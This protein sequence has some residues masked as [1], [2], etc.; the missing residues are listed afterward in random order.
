MIRSYIN[1]LE[2]KYKES[3][4]SD[5]K[6]FISFITD[7]AQR[8]S[9][10]IHDLLDYSRII[11]RGKEFTKVDSNEIISK[12][13]QNL[14]MYITENDAEIVFE[15]LPV[16]S[17]D[18]SQLIELFQNLINNAIKFRGDEKPIVHIGAIRDGRRWRFSVK[19]NGIGIK[20]D[21]FDK[22][23]IMFQRLHEREKYPGT[24]IGL[25]IVKKVVERHGGS[26]C[27]ESEPGKGT[28]FYFTLPQVS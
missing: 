8:M 7:G 20:K 23:F 25:A 16:V 10:L 17:G 5:A 1:L 3:L 22:I 9:D 28:T 2:S 6:Q 27:V 11:T 15:D 14:E 24:G 21:F 13:I 19:D 26:I 4:D 12:V 18:Q